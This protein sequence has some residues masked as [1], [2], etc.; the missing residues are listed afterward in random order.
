[1]PLSAGAN[2]KIAVIKPESEHNRCIFELKLDPGFPLKSAS[3]LFARPIPLIRVRSIAYAGSAEN[4][5]FQLAKD[6]DRTMV[7]VISE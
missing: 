4:H 5:G 2:D 1:M 7:C 6:A 3:P